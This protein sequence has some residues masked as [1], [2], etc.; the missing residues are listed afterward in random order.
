MQETGIPQEKPET[1]DQDR[2]STRA[3]IEEVVEKLTPQEQA[4][5]LSRLLVGGIGAGYEELLSRL[6][7]LDRQ[8]SEELALVE[9]RENQSKIG[10][11]S[12]EVNL[13][14]VNYVRLALSGLIF[15]VQRAVPKQLSNIRRLETWA[16]KKAKPVRNLILDNP[17]G[18]YFNERFDYLAD[19]GQST[20]E[21]WV[22][23]GYEEDPHNKLL[24][25]NTFIGIVDS[26]IN[27]L[28][29]NPEVQELVKTQ[30]TSLANEMVVEVR[31]RTVSADTFIEGLARAM[32]RRVPRSTIAGPSEEIRIKAVSPRLPNP[33]M[34]K[35]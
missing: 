35:K 24:A 12:E 22:E 1:L 8:I 21:R 2:I 28:T 17:V 27:Y 13:S 3:A 25:Q 32:V 29:E 26:I 9:S 11:E 19:R 18:R 6:Q 16:L 23:I 33:D 30:S 15:E 34:G 7:D 10:P 4:F 5:L 31:E 20:V 14:S